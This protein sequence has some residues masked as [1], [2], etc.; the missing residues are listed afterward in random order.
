MKRKCGCCDIFFLFTY[1]SICYLQLITP[2]SVNGMGAFECM[3]NRP[4]PN[5]RLGRLFGAS[6]SAGFISQNLITA[7]GVIT[8]TPGSDTD[9]EDD[10]SFATV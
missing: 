10:N 4:K 3:E 7:Q 8:E 9:D 5:K 2:L 6:Y 1:L